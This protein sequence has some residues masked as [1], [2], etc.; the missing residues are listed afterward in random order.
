MKVRLPCTHHTPCARRTEEP[1]NK[2][3][4]AHDKS[5]L[6]ARAG[7]IADTRIITAATSSLLRAFNRGKCDDTDANPPCPIRANRFQLPSHQTPSLSPTVFQSDPIRPC[8]LRKNCERLHPASLK[9]YTPHSRFWH[10]NRG[11]PRRK[12]GLDSP[13]KS[14]MLATCAFSPREFPRPWAT[15]RIEAL[16]VGYLGFR[17]QF[18]LSTCIFS[19]KPAAHARHS[20]PPRRAIHAI[21]NGKNQL[22]AARTARAPQTKPRSRSS[23]VPQLVRRMSPSVGALS[24]SSE[25]AGPRQRFVAE[26]AREPRAP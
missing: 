7:T 1:D 10:E 18:F 12:P 2:R 21:V 16:L 11:I 15:P 13:L 20:P 3:M 22:V 26:R 25:R 23:Y 5:L 14:R 9:K 17:A 19:G 24:L 8:S 6:L 4:K